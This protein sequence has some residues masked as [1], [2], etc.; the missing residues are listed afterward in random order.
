MKL[1]LTEG[2][3]H[4]RRRLLLDVMLRDEVLRGVLRGV[5]LISGSTE[6][7]SHVK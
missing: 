3:H 4:Q 1:L 6:L 5:T 7:A 2:G